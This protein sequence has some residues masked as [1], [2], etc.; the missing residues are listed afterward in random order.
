[1]R[2]E[3]DRNQLKLNLTH[4][5]IKKLNGKKAN[6]KQIIVEANK[7]FKNQRIRESLRADRLVVISALVGLGAERRQC[8]RL[9][10]MT[11]D[12]VSPL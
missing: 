11:A 10:T 7:T 5:K 4:V 1:M 12:N 3:T 2:S 6:V 9:S 8:Y